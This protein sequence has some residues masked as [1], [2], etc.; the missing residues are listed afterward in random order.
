MPGIFISYRRDDTEGHARALF[1]RLASRFGQDRVFMDVEG[2]GPGADFVEAIESAVG[3]CDVALVL[4]GPNWL[5][6]V[7]EHGK[8][9]IDD[10]VDFVRIETTAALARNIRVIPVL[11]RGAAMPPA[12]LL[13][14]ELAKLS[15][16]QA[17]TLRHERWERDTNDLIAALAKLIGGS[18]AP[19]DA[20]SG[21]AAQDAETALSSLGVAPKHRM[22]VWLGGG[23]VLATAVIAGFFALRTTIEPQPKPAPNRPEAIAKHGTAGTNVSGSSASETSGRAASASEPARSATAPT[24]GEAKSKDT[25]ARE[26]A[27]PPKGA[28]EPRNEGLPR[29]EGSPAR[30]AEGKS[31]GPR[32]AEEP[33]TKEKSAV[34]NREREPVAKAAES[35]AASSS[36]TANESRSRAG[37]IEKIAKELQARPGDKTSRKESQPATAPDNKVIASETPAPKEGKA[38]AGTPQ[39]ERPAIETPSSGKKEALAKAD[40]TASGSSSTGPRDASTSPRP[41]PGDTWAYRSHSIW[42]NV[43]ERTFQHHALVVSDSEIKESMSLSGAATPVD[44]Q[45]F[46]NTPSVIE[47]R[48]QGVTRQEFSPFLLAFGSVDVGRVWKSLKIPEEADPFFTGWYTEA[49]VI[50]WERVTVPAGSFNA[51]RVDVQSARRGTG[52]P[53][54]AS[55]E[56]ARIF[57]S[58]WFVPEVKRPV[59]EVRT[60]YAVGGNRLDQDTY[61]LVEYRLN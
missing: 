46:R 58:I 33:G 54:M 52:N 38:A 20:H 5:T 61:D 48:L 51:I 56:L 42:K 13:P 22:W 10:P 35:V 29:N 17:V 6:S 9:R 49:K 15:R 3:N 43:P 27:A 26:T 23:A 28:A 25:S 30:K 40:S 37:E 34:V 24:A 36:T 59:K 44:T 32:G 55:A 7:D 12:N 11:V 19:P 2:I 47:R 18:E 1:E 16:R 57:Q 39:I 45:T 31:E 50:G 8:R 53:A 21:D 4:I 41:K 14:P 60:T